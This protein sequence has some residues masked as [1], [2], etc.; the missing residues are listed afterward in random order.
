MITSWRSKSFNWD[1][2]EAVDDCVQYYCPLLWLHFPPISC[3]RFGK[4]QEVVLPNSNVHNKVIEISRR[5]CCVCVV[6]VIVQYVLFLSGTY[7][8]GPCRRLNVF[9]MAVEWQPAAISL[10]VTDDTYI[11]RQQYCPMGHILGQF[12]YGNCGILHYA[13]MS[14]D[15]I[16]F[17]T[18]PDS[19]LRA[20][21]WILLLICAL[22]DA[23]SFAL[24]V[25]DSSL[26]RAKR[27]TDLQNA[28][29]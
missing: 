6:A 3:E 18:N 29:H 9:E 27:W 7:P 15:K 10:I 25:S 13:V 4:Q 14:I 21:R 17:W 24:L 23:R 12:R 26:G 5:N 2:A 8:A 11:P 19:S 28:P 16:F 1:V 22:L 20:V